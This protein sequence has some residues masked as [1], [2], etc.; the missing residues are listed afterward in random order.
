MANASL[1]RAASH[2]P[3]APSGQRGAFAGPRSRQPGHGG[4]AGGRGAGF[5][6]RLPSGSAAPG[7]AAGRR[8]RT[9]RQRRRPSVDSGASSRQQPVSSRK[10]GMHAPTPRDIPRPHPMARPTGTTATTTTIAAAVAVVPAQVRAV[11]E[12]SVA[13]VPVRERR[14]PSRGSGGITVRVRPAAPVP[15]AATASVPALAPALVRAAASR[16]T[17]TRPE[18]VRRAAAVAVAAAR[19]AMWPS[20]RQ[21]V[22]GPQEPSR[23]ASGIPGDEGARHRRRARSRTGNGADRSACVRAPRSPISAEKINVNPGGA[24][25]PCCSHLGEMAT[26]TQ[27]LDESTFQIAGR[28]DRLR[29]SR[30]SP[31]RRRT[32]E[33]LRVSSTSTSTAEELQE[34]ADLKPRP[35]VVTVMGHVD[36]G[37]TRAARHH[38][39]DG[40][41]RPARHGGITQRIG[42][43]QVTVEA[44]RTSTARPR[45]RSSTPPATRRSPPCVPAAR[46]RHRCRDPRGRGR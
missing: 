22:Q 46:E 23:E 18:P 41:H 5:P 35:P 21:V 17:P 37:K 29:T 7:P 32:S 43:Y 36:H 15:R 25:S 3:H 20:G 39:P 40:R 26:A 9:F 38:P 2:N 16:T 14:A 8:Q 27:S 19:P 34:D 6:R 31:P 4:N 12:D 30:S 1:T 42:A 45:S 13:V 11:A 10:Q 44:G 24:W 33:L 28:G